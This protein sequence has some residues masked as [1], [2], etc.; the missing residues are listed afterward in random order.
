MRPPYWLAALN[1][2]AL[3]R[4]LRCAADSLSRPVRKPPAPELPSLPS[5]SQKGCRACETPAV[6]GPQITSRL[7]RAGGELRHCARGT[8]RE[9]VVLVCVARPVSFARS[10]ESGSHMASSV[11]LSPYPPC[12][13]P[14]DLAHRCQG[15]RPLSTDMSLAQHVHRCEPVRTQYRADTKLSRP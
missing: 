12:K 14:V 5:Q 8:E 6:G 3:D 15:T 2:C 4:E 13:S 10:Y 1:T 7:R 9:H 11:R